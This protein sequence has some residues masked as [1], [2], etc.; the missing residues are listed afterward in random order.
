MRSILLMATV[1]LGCSVFAPAAEA[2]GNVQYPWCSINR[3]GENIWCAYRS[4][5]QCLASISGVGGD[6]IRNPWFGPAPVYRDPYYA[7]GP[8][9]YPYRRWW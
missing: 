4:Y 1:V 7:P 3:R 6:C 9:P 5:Q 2:Q 8:A